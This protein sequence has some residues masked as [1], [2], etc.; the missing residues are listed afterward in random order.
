MTMGNLR[1]LIA[2]VL[3]PYNTMRPRK[4][5]KCNGELPGTARNSSI[6]PGPRHNQQ[7]GSV[8]LSALAQ[9]KKKGLGG[10]KP[11]RPLSRRA[12]VV[13]AAIVSEIFPG[14]LESILAP[15]QL[16]F[17]LRDFLL[18]LADLPAA[19]SDLLAARALTD[20]LSQIRS[21]SL[22]LGVILLQLRAVAM[23]IALRFAKLADFPISFL[24]AA[25]PVAVKI[26]VMKSSIPQF[27]M[28]PS[29]VMTDEISPTR[30]LAA[31]SPAIAGRGLAARR[32]TRIPNTAPARR[33][34]MT[35]RDPK[36]MVVPRR[37]GSPGRHQS[38]SQKSSQNRGLDNL[39]FSL[40]FLMHHRSELEWSNLHATGRDLT[41]G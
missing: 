17:A 5:C 39:H 3:L 12:K 24:V 13:L 18:I 19:L 28:V 29:S 22:E 6:G 41:I 8:Q 14:R 27:V 26:G 25:V 35:R 36:M 40:L 16:F 38:R 9:I 34:H 10:R 7:L 2:N 15:S 4:E 23:N 33:R 30:H 32:R 1:S 20:I 21:I 11:P 31:K 37:G